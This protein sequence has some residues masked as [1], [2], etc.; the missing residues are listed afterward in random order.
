MSISP[1]LRDKT[2]ANLISERSAN[3]TFDPS[4]PFK[5]KIDTLPDFLQRFLDPNTKLSDRS[6]KCEFISG[7]IY[8]IHPETPKFPRNTKKEALANHFMEK[9][10]PHLVNTIRARMVA[11]EIEPDNQLA[12][13]DPDASTSTAPMIRTAL[14]KASAQILL[15]KLQTK[16]ELVKIFKKLSNSCGSSGPPAIYHLDVSKPMPINEASKK[17]RDDLRYAIQYHRPD[18]FMPSTAISKSILLAAYD[19]FVNQAAVGPDV[20]VDGVHYFLIRP[21]P[22]FA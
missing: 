3:L 7:I 1:D 9:V 17:S 20:L 14:G 15:S 11:A 2:L 13:L 16:S 22:G 6:T 21:Q 18:I 19:K 12:S 8:W 10:F 5:A 4:E